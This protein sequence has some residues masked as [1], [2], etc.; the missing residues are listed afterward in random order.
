V[1]REGHTAIHQPSA[2]ALEQA[3]LEAGKWFADHDSAARSDNALPGNGLTARGGS[4]GSPGGPS[5]A[6]E[7]RG[8]GQLAVGKDAPLGDALD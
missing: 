7:S 2:F 6:R 8:A 5:A 3:A 4:H 1:F